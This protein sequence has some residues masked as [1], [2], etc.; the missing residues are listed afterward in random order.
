MRAADHGRAALAATTFLTRL[1]V[2]RG[3]ALDARAL[4]HGAVFFP[5]VGGAI[6]ASVGAVAYGLA[7]VVPSLVAAGLALA[8]GAVLT[9][10][11]HL[12]G[13]ADTADA[14]GAHSREAALAIMRDHATGA[15]GVSALALDLLVKAAALAA[16]APHRRVVLFALVAGALGR[17]APAAVAAVLPSARADGAGAAFRVSPPRALLA[18]LTAAAISFANGALDALVLCGVAV[19]VAGTLAL[20]FRRWFGGVTGDTLGA[21][22]ELTET[23]LLVA[24]A[25]LL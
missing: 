6:G 1:P 8:V 18:C 13:L 9:G 12:D 7:Q 15:Y 21:A 16:L 17:A 2:G 4:A 5:L 19:V 22:A 3:I 11:L 25:G 10:A 24:S 14:L 23:A 20:C